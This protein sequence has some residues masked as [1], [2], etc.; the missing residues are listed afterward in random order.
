MSGSNRDTRY[1]DI[2]SPPSQNAE[3]SNPQAPNENVTVTRDSYGVPHVYADTS[4]DLFYGYGYVLAEDRL[5]QMEMAR[6][7]VLG[8][9]AEVLGP[10]HRHR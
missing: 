7:A 4:Y 10:E 3:S 8:T 9:S 2:A 5:F 6:R 1:A